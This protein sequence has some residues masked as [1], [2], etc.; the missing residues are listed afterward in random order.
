MEKRRI[1]IFADYFEQVYQSSI[2][3]ACLRQLRHRG[4]EG[5]VYTAANLVH[6]PGFYDDAGLLFRLFPVGLDGLILLGGNFTSHPSFR[7]TFL[8]TLPPLPTVSLSSPLDQLA[9]V[10]VDNREGM[11]RI[12]RHLIKDHGLKKI[13]FIKKLEGHFEGEQR[14]QAWK[15]TLE[16]LGLSPDPR[17]ILPGEFYGDF[18]GSVAQ[19]FDQRQLKPG[20]DLEALVFVD[21]Y[22]LVNMY[23]HLSKRGIRIPQELAVACFDAPTDGELPFQPL[24]E[25]Q[26][27]ERMAFQAVELILGLIQ[28]NAEVP[29]I[30]VPTL[31]IP[32]NSCGCEDPLHSLSQRS[33]APWKDYPPCPD[34]SFLETL[35]GLFGKVSETSDGVYLRTIDQ[36]Q[37]PGAFLPDQILQAERRY[38]Y[39]G[40][41]IRE[42]PELTAVPPHFGEQ[43]AAYTQEAWNSLIQ[44]Q[45]R[46]ASNH[47]ITDTRIRK[48]LTE[49][50]YG[51]SEQEVIDSFFNHLVR[52]GLGECFVLVQSENHILRWGGRLTQGQRVWEEA[53]HPW[54]PSVFLDEDFRCPPSFLFS[55]LITADLEPLGFIGIELPSAY[56]EDF[57]V[58]ETLVQVLCGALMNCR[59]QL[60]KEQSLREL[61]KTR[62]HLLVSEK[63]A[64]LGGLVAGMAHEINTPIGNAVTAASFAQDAAEQLCRLLEKPSITKSEVVQ[65]SDNMKTAADMI[66]VNC[67]R[68][69]D[70]IQS[71]KVISVDQASD[72]MREFDLALYL[73]EII[74]SLSPR[75]KN[76]DVKIQ[77]DCPA[78]IL[79]QSFPGSFSQVFTNLVMNSLIHGF[80]NKNRG[81]ILITIRVEQNKILVVRYQDN[82]VGMEPESLSHLFEPFYTS[83]KNSGG[84]G[85]GTYLVYTIVTQHLKGSV[86]VESTQ[87]KGLKYTF[88][89]PLQTPPHG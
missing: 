70:L 9:S 59:N 64:L 30:E 2:I 66:L 78:G 8:N 61:Q 89:I 63:M 60:A 14:F 51:Q 79:I 22:S 6:T 41:I 73:D 54:E 49:G 38:H 3:R 44:L 45:N 53:P 21:S 12:T 67:R 37:E 19:L 72:Q 33:F 55:P 77:V 76:T 50:V 84:S 65:L 71:F 68:A 29:L 40:P 74:L 62:E 10:T 48:I 47:R 18:P 25:A 81:Q 87:G 34:D 39:L 16:S 58:Y 82:G 56:W 86:H 85:L 75:L 31:P 13:G 36:D 32:G 7:N 35:Q 20:R 88:R 15:G 24:C 27:F 1:G 28:K 57:L 11:E 23:P 52:L 46:Q 26:P 17:L 80:K 83:R 4:C 69:A 42:F 5:V 43:L